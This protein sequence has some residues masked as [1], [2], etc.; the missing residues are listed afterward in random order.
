[1]QPVWIVGLYQQQLCM[2]CQ[3]KAELWLCLQASRP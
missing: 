2:A 3:H 1:M